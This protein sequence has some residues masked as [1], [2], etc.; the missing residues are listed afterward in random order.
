MV[1]HALRLIAD[2]ALG[3]DRIEVTVGDIEW[4]IQELER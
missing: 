3:N 2:R 4:A 1:V